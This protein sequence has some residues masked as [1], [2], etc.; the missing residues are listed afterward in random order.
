MNFKR[1]LLIEKK[2]NF[3][4]FEHTKELVVNEL[5][6]EIDRL[7]LKELLKNFKYE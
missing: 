6:K 3:C 5:E 4:I 7:I 2:N 1:R